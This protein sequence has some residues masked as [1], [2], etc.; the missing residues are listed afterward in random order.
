MTESNDADGGAV[1]DRG[2]ATASAESTTTTANLPS[3]T[4]LPSATSNSPP[5]ASKTPTQAANFRMVNFKDPVKS[6]D[7]YIVVWEKCR[8][9]GWKWKNAKSKGGIEQEGYNYF[10][11]NARN[12]KQGATAGVDYVEGEDGVREFARVHWAAP[13]PSGDALSRLDVPSRAFCIVSAPGIP[14]GMVMSSTPKHCTI[15]YHAVGRNKHV[16][17]VSP[18]VNADK[19][20]VLQGRAAGIGERLST[21]GKE[22]RVGKIVYHE[23]T[24]RVGLVVS[25]DGGRLNV[26]YEEEGEMVKGGRLGE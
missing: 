9:T 15:A 12:Y 19:V 3:T 11:P 14:T 21:V 13:A 1:E 24:R 26:W 16:Y 25:L 20:K 22:E 18:R 5:T 4:K 17:S 8:A 2:V 6:N 10:L 7:P 23:G